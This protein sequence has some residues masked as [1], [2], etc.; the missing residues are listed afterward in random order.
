MEILRNNE[1]STE[2]QVDFLFKKLPPELA[3]KWRD[4]FIK[5]KQTP[6]KI[7]QTLEEII[8]ERKSSTKEFF[9]VY[10]EKIFENNLEGG[11]QKITE[12]LIE[13]IAAEAIENKLNCIGEGFTAKVVTSKIDSRFCFKVI[14]NQKEY[15]KGNNVREEME[16][17]DKVCDPNNEYGVKIP[18]PYYYQMSKKTHVCVMERLNA[19]NF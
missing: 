19:F 8:A 5:E 12:E 7:R 18:K 10:E 16:F 9:S 15:S 14:T 13:H 2:E 6:E 4:K 17:L 11:L 1:P 3:A